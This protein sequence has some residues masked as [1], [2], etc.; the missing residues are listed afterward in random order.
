L[1]PNKTKTN[2]SKYITNARNRNLEFKITREQFD[3]LIIQKCYLCGVKPYLNVGIDRFDNT[4]GYDFDNV[5]P[6][7]GVCNTMKNNHTYEKFLDKCV[8]IYNY[9]KHGII[10]NGDSDEDALDDIIDEDTYDKIEIEVMKNNTECIPQIIETNI[11]TNE[12]I[13]VDDKTKNIDEIQ[14]AEEKPKNIPE[15]YKDGKT[16]EE[17]L[18]E[19]NRLKKQRQR[20]RQREKLGEEEFKKLNTEKMAAYRKNKSSTT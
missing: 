15:I 7:C 5:R 16:K 2:Y 11:G 17:Y 3:I 14:S 12:K 6:C 18:R 10:T 13:P 20:E 8:M 1:T 19:L 9:N 4:K